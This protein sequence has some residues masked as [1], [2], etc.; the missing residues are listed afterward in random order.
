MSLASGTANSGQWQAQLNTTAIPD[1]LHKITVTATD[2]ASPAFRPKA[3]SWV[4]AGGV[5]S[6][7]L[8]PQLVNL[9]MDLWSP[10]LFMAS[11]AAQGLVAL[12]VTIRLGWQL[13][14]PPNRVKSSGQYPFAILTAT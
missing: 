11:F 10:Y 7:V 8:G 14:N 12:M 3:I 2:T 4:M 5:F 13:P 9:T 1:G 6:G